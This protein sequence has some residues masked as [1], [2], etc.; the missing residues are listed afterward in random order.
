MGL[1]AND[2]FGAQIK[3]MESQGEI[4]VADLKDMMKIKQIKKPLRLYLDS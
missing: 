2:A 4:T 3:E 1:T